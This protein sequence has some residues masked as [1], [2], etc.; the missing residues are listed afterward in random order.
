MPW[1]TEGSE[2][3]ALAA[4]L[5]AEVAVL[6]AHKRLQHGSH[7]AAPGAHA[8]AL[9]VE[10]RVRQLIGQATSEELLAMQPP[11]WRAWL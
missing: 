11:S 3:H 8:S 5:D 10:G 4:R 2:G 7:G 9:S 6:H 1:A